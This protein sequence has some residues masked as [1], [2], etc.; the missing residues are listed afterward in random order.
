MKKL[1]YLFVFII[2][3][4]S[5]YP[6]EFEWEWQNAKPN[7]NDFMDVQYLLPT[8]VISFGGASSVLISTNNGDQWS[9]SYADTQR[10][11][12]WNSY[13]FDANTGFLCG[14]GGLL[15]KT[16]DGGASWVY[17]NSST[18][19]RLYDIEFANANSGIAVGSSGT[20]I[21]TA[22]GGE[23]WTASAYGTS[24]HYKVSIAGLDNI[25]IGSSSSTTGRLLKSTDFGATWSNV[26]PAQI[27]SSV[28][29]MFVMNATTYYVASGVNGIL[30]T[31]DSGA[32]W[33]VQQAVGNIVYD[34]KFI[35]ASTGFAVDSKGIVYKTTDGGTNWGSS[36]LP[37]NKAVRAIGY[38]A[39]SLFL[40]GNSANLFYSSD[41]GTNWTPKFTAVTQDYLRK[42]YFK[43]SLNGWACGGATA[44]ADSNG[45]ILQTTDGGQNWTALP[46]N[47]KSQVYSMSMP[48]ANVWYAGRGA[49]GFFKTTDAGATF[50]QLS[51]PITSSTHTFWFTGF[52]NELV[53]YAGGNSGKVIKTTDGG[54]T[55]SDIST[56]AGFGT[57]TVYDI[58]VI[59]PDTVIMCGL[60]AKVMKTTDGGATFS[61]LSPGI[62]GSLFAVS[63]KDASFGILGGSSLGVSVTTDG[64]A[65]WTP[66]NLPPTLSSSTSIWGFGFG[67]S[68]IWLSTINGDLLYSSDAGLNFNETRKPT[69]NTIF[70]L[71]VV[72]DD[73]WASGSG[74]V[75]VKGF[76]DPNIPVELLSFTGEKVGSTV[77]LHWSTATETNNLGFEVQKKNSAGEWKA[78]SFING[79]G[80]S[81]LRHDYTYTDKNPAGDIITYRLKQID[82]DGTYKYHS[83]VQVSFGSPVSFELTQN[84]P[85]PFNPATTIN[86]SVPSTGF[87]ELK[88]FNILGKEIST[89]VNSIQESGYYNISFDAANLPSGVYFYQ[90]KAGSFTS[91]RKMIV[92]K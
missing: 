50:T 34:V 14:D 3:Q 48:S 33:T 31:T 35:D 81:T 62:A 80:T 53:G 6:Q 41:T 75:I 63:F 29:G 1:L 42:I 23:T 76:S 84:Y 25:Y 19:N 15:M 47:F 49:N 56:A 16:T 66:S 5:V 26:T 22:D 70:A 58:A 65:T 71:T 68:H 86:Y 13:F 28:Y 89:L 82:M 7:G 92:L 30:I 77:Q 24:S 36:Q 59:S 51:T 40:C 57:S 11:D 90:L 73:L 67:T 45:F 61:P 37:N 72:G 79:N 55:W 85:N 12:I 21:T 64:G 17:K 4:F 46:Y 52:A 60:S 91:V 9:V 8:K 69:T 88:V 2:S 78:L 54:A 83:S 32:N 18:T 44:S 74:G 20:V 43:T 10:R 38:A 27:S 39:G 87:V